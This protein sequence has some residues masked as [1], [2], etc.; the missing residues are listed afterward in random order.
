MCHCPALPGTLQSRTS[1]PEQTPG[2]LCRPET[3]VTLLDHYLQYSVTIFR[4]TCD[5][6]SDLTT[7]TQPDQHEVMD[8]IG[9]DSY[10]RLAFVFTLLSTQTN[11]SLVL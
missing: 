5:L 4:F 2:P 8:H 10:D 6:K 7:Q 1:T 3:S 11:G 9:Y